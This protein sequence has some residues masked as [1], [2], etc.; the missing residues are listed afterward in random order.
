MFIGSC[1]K[2]GYQ[3]KRRFYAIYKYVGSKTFNPFTRPYLDTLVALV[4]LLLATLLLLLLALLLAR[5]LGAGA[6]GLGLLALLALLATGL[7]RLLGRLLAVSVEAALGGLGRGVG[8]LLLLLGALLGRGLLGLVLLDLAGSLG[9]LVLLAVGV[10]VG[11]DVVLFRCEG[12]R[13]CLF[14]CLFGWLVGWGDD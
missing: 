4:L 6:L 7:G 10:H 14:V 11:W 12:K 1:C 3:G 13:V 2:P 8:V 5:L 9:L